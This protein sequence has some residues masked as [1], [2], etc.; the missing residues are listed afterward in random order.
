[1]TETPNTPP[2]R[3]LKVARAIKWAVVACLVLAILVWIAVRVQPPQQSRHRDRRPLPNVE[4]TESHPQPA[5]LLD[6]G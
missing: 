6:R 4:N 2:S 3:S 1:M 5:W